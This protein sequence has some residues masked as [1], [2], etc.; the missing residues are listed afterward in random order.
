MKLLF[1]LFLFVRLWSNNNTLRCVGYQGEKPF[2]ASQLTETKEFID[3]LDTDEGYKACSIVYGVRYPQKTFLVDFGGDIG[4]LAA[5]VNTYVFYHVTLTMAL[6]GNII[7]PAE[8]QKSFSFTCNNQNA[9]E[10]QFWRDHIDW[11]IE[12]ESTTL[13]AVFRSILITENKEK[14]KIDIFTTNINLS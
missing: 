3:N 10:R 13:E 2:K 14:G 9:C 1:L 6:N 8:G 12:E 11:F 5:N 4:E 7:D